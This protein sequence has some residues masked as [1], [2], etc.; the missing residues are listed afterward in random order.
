MATEL[1]QDAAFTDTSVEK[2]AGAEVE[3]E[4]GPGMDKGGEDLGGLDAEEGG[5]DLE[6][7]PPPV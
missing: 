4:A 7:L 1:G 3:P 6:E 2:P 5:E